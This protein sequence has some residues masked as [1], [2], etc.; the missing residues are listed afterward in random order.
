VTTTLGRPAA[1]RREQP[2]LVCVM[3]AAVVVA[4][5]LAYFRLMS[6]AVPHLFARWP[7]DLLGL[8]R[9]LVDV[10]PY[11]LLALV[12]L[13]WGR[14]VSQGLRGALC[15]LVA[16][17]ADWGLQEAENAVFEHHRLTQTDLRLFD[18]TMT[19]LLPTLVALAWGLARRSGRAWL[20]GVLVAPGLAAVRHL[21]ETRSSAYGTWELHHGQ[22]WVG[23]LEFVAP[24]VVACLVCWL[25]EH[26][27]PTA[28]IES[29]A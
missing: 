18:W 25:I 26:A 12:L 10:S 6:N 17:I 13:V 8:L 11:A 16:G 20:V 1:S 27:W 7:D 2:L 14:S 9:L 23:R 22:W 24:M 29:S 3:V 4:G 28:E 19:L 15:A 21:L 5:Y